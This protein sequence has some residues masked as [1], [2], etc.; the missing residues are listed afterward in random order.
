M[1]GLYFP[2]PRK[3]RLSITVH[4]MALTRRAYL[5]A[6]AAALVLFAFP[7]PPAS[8]QVGQAPVLSATAGNGEVDLSWTEWDPPDDLS[9]IWL[10]NVVVRYTWQKKETDGGSWGDETYVD[11]T[12]VTVTDLENGTTYSFRVRGHQQGDWPDGSR[13]WQRYSPPSTEVTATPS[14][15]AE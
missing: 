15:D 4:G 1:F 11:D 13:Q 6:F 14:D 7:P 3:R 9:S 5:V 10:K 2:D 8:A 12:A